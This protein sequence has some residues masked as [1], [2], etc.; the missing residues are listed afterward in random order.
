MEEVETYEGVEFDNEWKLWCRLCAKS[1]TEKVNIFTEWTQ[2]YNNYK[3]KILAVI[4]KFFHIKV[5]VLLKKLAARVCDTQE[6]FS[7]LEESS[8]TTQDLE[9]LF[10]KYGTAYHGLLIKNTVEL[11]EVQSISTCIRDSTW[12][13]RMTSTRPISPN[14]IIREKEN[15]L[16]QAILFENNDP[17][18]P[19]EGEIFSHGSSCEDAHSCESDK[20]FKKIAVEFS[21]TSLPRRT[22]SLRES[23][24]ENNYQCVHCPKRF[25]RIGSYHIHLRRKHG[26]IKNVSPSNEKPLFKCKSCNEAFQNKTLMTQ[27]LKSKHGN[28]ETF[29]CEECGEVIIGSIR[30]LRDHMLTHTNYAPFECN[31]CGKCF[32]L[33]TRLKRHMDIHGEKHICNECGLQL[34][35]RA[36]LYHHSFVHSDAMPHKCDYCGRAFKRSKTLKNHLILH[37][38]LKP[39]ACDFCE[40]TFT[41]GTSYRTH[42]KNMHPVE[43]ANQEASGEKPNK[44]KNIPKLSVL[45]SV[46]RTALNL[47]PVAPK[48]SGNFSMGK[49]PKLGRTSSKQHP[50]AVIDSNCADFV[51][52][53]NKTNLI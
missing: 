18:D 1:N 44:A 37:T 21:K 17:T 26:R 13:S 36:T 48:R 20:G 5:H 41:N 3:R 38:G 16:I 32:K 22:V 6:M 42:K 29:V 24:K 47:K 8:G 45:K 35:S 52:N 34:S 31:V 28:K 19:L 49:K 23:I 10:E 7:I 43:F 11:T 40:M 14:R 25:Q 27:H 50:A 33:K 39:Y 9:K 51:V 2:P 46:T 30:T 12:D 15:N 4:N 53:K